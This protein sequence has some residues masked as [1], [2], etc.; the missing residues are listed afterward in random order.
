MRM[1]CAAARSHM[2]AAA[3]GRENFVSSSSC[4]LRRPWVSGTRYSSFSPDSTGLMVIPCFIL[5]SKLEESHP[6]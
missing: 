5:S 4:I 6:L 1:G 3:E 2:S